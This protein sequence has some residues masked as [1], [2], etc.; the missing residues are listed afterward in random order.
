MIVV[1]SWRSVRLGHCYECGVSS[2]AHGLCE[3]NDPRYQLSSRECR[4]CRNCPLSSYS[5]WRNAAPITLLEMPSALTVS[6][7][8]VQESG[9]PPE[10]GVCLHCRAQERQRPPVVC[11][12]D[13]ASAYGGTWLWNVSV[14]R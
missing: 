14:G 8:V 1:E 11:K 2:S 13:A 3:P 9:Q 12:P 6:G 10:E 4:T 7:S 5:Q